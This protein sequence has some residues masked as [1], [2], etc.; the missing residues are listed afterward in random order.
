MK[1]VK[2]YIYILMMLVHTNFMNIEDLTVLVKKILYC[3]LERNA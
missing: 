3:I 1:K 2:K